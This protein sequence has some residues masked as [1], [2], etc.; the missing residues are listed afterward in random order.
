MID[1]SSWPVLI[2]WSAIV[3]GLVI[4][5]L[6]LVR[7]RPSLLVGGAILMLP[8]SLYL[9]ATPRFQYVGFVPVACL[10]LAACAVRRNRVWPGGLLVAGG[11]FFWS[12]V[13]EMLYFPILVH[14]LVRGTAIGIVAARRLS[15][16]V[17]MYVPVGIGGAFVGALLSFGDAPF[18]M[19]HPILN[20]WTLSVLAAALFVTALRVVDKRV[21]RH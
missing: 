15:W 8:I 20:P 7:R 9:T 10:L 16:K 2:F 5:G 4:S 13:A 11:V 19:R 6:G 1:V 17:A 12:V 3:M 21:F 18:L 14:V